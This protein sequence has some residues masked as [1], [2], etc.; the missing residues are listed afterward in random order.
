VIPEWEELVGRAGRSRI[1]CGLKNLAR[2]GLL[3]CSKSSIELI[4]SPDELRTEGLSG[5]WEAFGRVGNAAKRSQPVPVPRRVVRLLAGGSVGRG[6]GATMLGVM[7]R[8]LYRK[9]I[10]GTWV[11]VSGGMVSAAWVCGVFGIGRATVKHAFSHLEN[12]GWLTRLE[13]PHWPRQQQGGRTVIDLTWSRPVGGQGGEHESTPQTGQTEQL[14][15]PPDSI[16][17]LSSRRNKHQDPAS[18][19]P[20]GVSKT[21]EQEKSPSM[22]RIK[23]ADLKDTERL[24]GLF[25]DATAKGF[26]NGSPHDR[27][28]FVAAAERALTKGTENP[29]GLFFRLVHRKLWHH[30]T[31]DDE[32]A[33]H[34]RLKRHFFGDTQQREPEPKQPRVSPRVELSEDAR[35]VSAVLTV[36]R[37]R[38]LRCEPFYLLR[39]EY[40]GW[41]RERWDAAV[42]EIETARFRQL[43]VNAACR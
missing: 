4:Q 40:P 10:D 27:L 24:L 26:V 9:R 42:D 23:V 8:C 33:A 34:A 31:N 30:I 17:D 11:C 12:I 6:V 22:R 20:V 2:L 43:Q 35:L 18:G 29:C 21:K 38:R 14:S 36:I 28:V 5:Y 3:R 25:G 41:T 39:R 7:L 37:E 19:G 13:T 32:D 15:T 1:R 16:S